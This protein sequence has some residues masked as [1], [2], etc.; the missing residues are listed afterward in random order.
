MRNKPVDQFAANSHSAWQ[1]QSNWNVDGGFTNHASADNGSYGGAASFSSQARGHSKLKGLKAKLTKGIKQLASTVA[2]PTSNP[3]PGYAAP[4]NFNDPG[5]YPAN[6]PYPANTGY[7]PN[8]GYSANTGYQGSTGFP[9]Q[10]PYP[11]HATNPAHDPN[12]M[13]PAPAAFA[14]AGIGGATIFAHQGNFLGSA[15]HQKKL[16]Q[17]IKRHD[18]GVSD[19]W[20]AA[21]GSNGPNQSAAHDAHQEQAKLEAQRQ[22]Q[23][24][25]EAQQQEQIDLE[26]R[27]QEQILDDARQQQQADCLADQMAEQQAAALLEQQQAEQAAA[28]Y[29]QQGY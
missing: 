3:T 17:K 20:N 19:D 27:Q 10:A 24:V 16:L 2:A 4:P 18:P 28:M 25:L 8:P 5:N 6:N 23:I 9:P 1:A 11:T 29:A 13:H 21:S 22:E 14:G 12:A 15:A 7:P 26:A